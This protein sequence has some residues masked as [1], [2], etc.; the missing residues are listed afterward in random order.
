[1]VWKNMSGQES[2]FGYV[3][4]V[5]CF[6]SGVGDVQ[7]DVSEF[8]FF[9]IYQGLFVWVDGGYCFFM[10]IF[11]LVNLMIGYVWV[12]GKG[13]VK[14]VVF[15]FLSLLYFCLQY[16]YYCVECV[17]G[18]VLGIGG[19]KVILVGLKISEIYL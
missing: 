13:I 2:N 15:I 17:L 1:M 18:G 4:S 11:G 12:D 5:L 16:D 3:I 14:L 9:V 8:E 7:V 6:F 19:G 10:L